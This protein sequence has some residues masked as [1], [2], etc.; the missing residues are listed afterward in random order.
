[1][2]VEVR[3]RADRQLDRHRL[4][5]QAVDDHC[6]RALERGAGA[7]HLVDEADPGHPVLVGLPPNRL[8][9]RLD[10]G[11]GVEDDDAAVEHAQRALDLDREVDVAGVSMMLIWW[12]LH[13]AL[14]AAAVIVIPRSRSWTIQSIVAA[15][16]CTS[17]IL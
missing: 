10:P 15:P 7:V 9:L 3:F 2:P 11:D 5:F 6:D 8:R 12:P 14:V 1:M 4:R 17:P 13:S 16:S